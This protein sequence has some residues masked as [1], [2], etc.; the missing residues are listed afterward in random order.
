MLFRV[1]VLERNDKILRRVRKIVRG[2]LV[3]C[4]VSY[5]CTAVY[6]DFYN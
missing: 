1:E 3:P 2:D 4:E 5:L 6:Q